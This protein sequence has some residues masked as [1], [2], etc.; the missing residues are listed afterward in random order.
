[1]LLPSVFAAIGDPT[2][3]AIV[4]RL[5]RSDATILELAEPFPMT[6]QAVAKHVR[7]LQRA[8]VVRKTKI[9]RSQ[10]C[11][12]N[13]DVLC[14]ARSWIDELEQEWMARLDRLGAYL[15]ETASEEKRRQS[16]GSA[17]RPPGLRKPEKR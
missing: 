5:S 4:E 10:H 17:G 11:S 13:V 14:E 12:L 16:N 6:L 1:M 8:G 7:A 2:R 9:G 15:D 3:K